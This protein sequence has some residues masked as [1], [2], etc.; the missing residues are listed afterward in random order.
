MKFLLVILILF[1][2]GCAGQQVNVCP[3]GKV[4]VNFVE[5]ETIGQIQ[6]FL[7]SIDKKSKACKGQLQA[8]YL[9]KTKQIYATDL[10][11]AHHELAHYC[12]WRHQGD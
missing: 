3:L 2:S 11:E 7:C 5:P 6:G 12:G 1:F 9:P 10:E 4:E 8:V